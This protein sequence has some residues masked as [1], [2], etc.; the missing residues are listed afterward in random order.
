MDSNFIE[1]I[2]EDK[3][4]NPFKNELEMGIN[5]S[6][7]SFDIKL[8]CEL[9]RIWIILDINKDTSLNSHQVFE[10]VKKMGL[11]FAKLDESHIQ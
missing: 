5:M 1:E 10:C 7:I 11:K 8:T 3:E 2:K 6:S 4:R 9:E